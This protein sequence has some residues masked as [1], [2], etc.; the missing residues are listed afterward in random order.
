M[1]YTL[2]LEADIINCISKKRG[3][4]LLEGKDDPKF[5]DRL[6]RD[7]NEDLNKKLVYRKIGDYGEGS[8]CTKI[9]S[10]ISS[11]EDIFNKYKNN[12]LAIIDGDAK[13]F[14]DINKLKALKEKEYIFIL[15]FYSFESYCFDKYVLMDIVSRK[16]SA[17]I[18]QVEDGLIE[19]I[20]KYIEDKIKN[21]L[22]YISLSCLDSLMNEKI[23]NKFTYNCDEKFIKSP[24]C[25]NNILKQ[26]LEYN[27]NELDNFAEIN[28]ITQDINVIKKIAKGKHLLMFCASEI[29]YV[30][31]VINENKI[32]LEDELQKLKN[33]LLIKDGQY[34]IKCSEN[35]ICDKT[36]C[37][38]KTDVGA[39]SA[40]RDLFVDIIYNDLKN[41]TKSKELDYIYKRIL[42]FAQ[43]I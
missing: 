26:F 23:H 36:E 25:R 32:C 16:T 13:A 43:N 27:K 9:E 6:I 24:N 8:G 3:L 22:Y 5:Y 20:N 29:S 17:T 21:D 28:G 31:S 19:Y 1:A 37:I 7:K 10:V 39:N 33:I 4:L 40:G 34:N 41:N 2:S 11:K 30:L 35:Y 42:S 18:S 14:K 38:F 15:E 12:I